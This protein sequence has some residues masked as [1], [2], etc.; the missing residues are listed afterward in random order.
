MA[1]SPELVHRRLQT[2]AGRF[3]WSRAGRYLISGAA[4]SLFFMVVFLLVDSQ[5]HVGAFGRWF[6]FVLV[7]A[8]ALTGMGLAVPAFLRVL[9]EMAIARRIENACTG[10]GNAL[11][12]AVQFDRELKQGTAMRAAIF[13][14]LSDPFPRVNWTQ[15]F[16]LKLLRRLGIALVAV[17]SIVFLWAVLK[18]AVFANSMARVF[19][20]A[21][22]IEPL[23]RTRLEFLTPG[24]T[25]VTHGSA[26][27]VLARFGGDVPRTAWV[28]FRE[29]G[30]TWQRELMSREVGQA[31][32]HYQWK[33]VLQPVE[34]YV[35][36]GDLQTTVFR[37]A[38]RPK[39]AVKSKAAEI[40]PPT[41]SRLPKRTISG[42][43][44]LEGVLP[45]STV[46]VT[47]DF[48]N[49]VDALTATDDKAQALTTK[50]AADGKW[51]VDLPVT[52]NNKISLAFHDANDATTTETLPVAIKVDEPPK[53]NISEPA[54]GRELIADASAS[55]EIQ[56][57]ATDDLGLANVALYR[58]TPEKADAEP[59]HDWPAAEGQKSFVGTA[60]IPL[61]AY[62]KPGE[63]RVTFCLVARDANNVTGPGV[64]ISRPLTVSVA[65]P[66]KLQKQAGDAA[67]KLNEG[68]RALVKLQTTNLEET[69]GAQNLPEAPVTT[70]T[71]LLNRQ[72][73][74]GD[75]ARELVVSADSVAP[76]IRETL[77]SLVQQEM[78][79]AVL[80]LRN[81]SNAEAS[82]RGA[83]L[84]AAG[85]LETLILARLQGSPARADEEARREIIQNIISG[86]DGLLRDQRAILKDLDGAAPGAASALSDRQDKLADQ[87]VKVRKEVEKN[88]GN[89]SLGEAD[90]RVR[91]GK[92][93]AMFGE[94]RIYEEM[95]ATA[96]SLGSKA[97]PAAAARGGKVA[98]NLSKM[99][100]L[101]TQWQL[102]Q[103]GE[104][105]DALR[106][107]AEKM[108]G[109]LDALAEL[110]REVLEKSKELARKD[111]FSAEDQNAAAEIAKT[112]D[113]MAK[114]LEQMLTDAS[115]FPDMV[116]ANELRRQLV[117]V[118]EDV[119][120]EDLGDIAKN[121]LKPTDIAVQKED[122]LMKAIEATKKIPEDMEMF[123]PNKS[124]TTNWLLE[125][126]D[127]TEIPKLDNLPL[128]DEF[129]DLIGDLQK[130]QESIEDKVQSAASNQAIKAMQQ[131]G[132]VAD[133][134][135]DGY[136]A[137][138]KSGNQKPMDFEQAGRSS[139]GREGES[140]GEM[141]GKVA[142]DL[143]GR[144]THTRRTSD[145]MQS[146]SVEDN[147]GKAADARATG[148]GKAGGFSQREGMDGD[149]PVRS[150]I[151][152]RQA[153]ANA[154][155]AAQALIAQKTSKKAAAAT[156][157]YLRSDKLTSVAGMME[158][159]ATALREGR[160]ADFQGLH[161][162]I[163]A[164]LN[165]A[166][167]EMVSGKVLKL[168]TGDA[169]R[170]E[171]QQMLGGGEGDAPAPYKDRVADYYRSLADGK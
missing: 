119:K 79:A 53:L 74:V 100:A 127:K 34:Y 152:P 4:L 70:V 115:I 117:A 104:Q 107:E 72:V 76:Q 24:D 113:L 32:F 52:G 46:A 35:E 142:D 18:P 128:P 111:Q 130:D 23:T 167:G 45:G 108:K 33:S 84:G 81:A 114:V 11:V 123:L 10:S 126:F 75:A 138:G 94:F 64:T 166:K 87:S 16:D 89:M 95:L 165:T 36:A 67:A 161:K 93:V 63:E 29:A 39:T 132:A 1:L 157:L 71:T 40:T 59:V 90:F 151:A 171:D 140:N 146:G 38:V 51:N 143:E 158:E 43:S 14:E 58:S 86:V 47:L 168:A 101:L 6:G 98:D 133:G 99:V 121:K 9:P 120:Q 77:R 134:M 110:Q 57:A 116:I 135:Q 17:T 148:G 55:L 20:P 61:A 129:T 160:L 147:S 13:D 122:S 170:K 50:R 155:A 118:F 145:P 48:N 19:L 7:V 28:R 25:A 2:A 92:I 3:R 49:P 141:A 96:D 31:E 154:A 30:S 66:E 149:A 27:D 41:Y 106:K 102:A 150:G 131:G 56:F 44:A 136:S 156:L 65:T 54:E 12:N 103:V 91:L 137:Q 124:A 88:A 112:K 21:R 85:K 5:F 125:N 97:F 62:L 159:S 78:P 105:A 69:Q 42:F 22:H 82:T 144:K 26:L 164:Q 37:V 60:K 68:L 169:A 153:A 15:V 139:G 8:P 109:K 162:K 80:T 163:I 83:L 73:A